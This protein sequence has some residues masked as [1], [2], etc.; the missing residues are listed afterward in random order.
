MQIIYHPFIPRLQ[1]SKE[2]TGSKK[3]RLV[4]KSREEVHEDPIELIFAFS[5][6]KF[7]YGA[8]LKL[9]TFSMDTYGSL[10]KNYMQGYQLLSCSV[11]I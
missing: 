2:I 8:K 3:H 6:E 5:F 10:V 7:S 9:V 4:K 1:G 11:S